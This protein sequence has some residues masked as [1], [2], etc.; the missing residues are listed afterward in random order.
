MDPYA[1]LDQ[2]TAEVIDAMRKIA[3]NRQQFFLVTWDPDLK[4]PDGEKGGMRVYGGGEAK[5]YLESVA[6]CISSIR[7]IQSYVHDLLKGNY[8]VQEGEGTSGLVNY[9]REGKLN[10]LP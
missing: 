6:F 3:H 9:T 8:E 1:E 7:C 2:H 10:D 4:G 5:N